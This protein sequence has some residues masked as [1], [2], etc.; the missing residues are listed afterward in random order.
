MRR[1]IGAHVLER[2]AARRRRASR[3]RARA[4]VQRP[5]VRRDQPSRAAPATP[6]AAGRTTRSAPG[7][8]SSSVPRRRLPTSMPTALRVEK[9]AEPSLHRAPLALGQALA[10]Q[11]EDRRPRIARPRRRRP[12]CACTVAS[13][14]TVRPSK[15]RSRISRFSSAPCAR[16]RCSTASKVPRPDVGV[17]REIGGGELGLRAVAQERATSRGWRRS[18]R[19]SR[20]AQNSRPTCCRAAG[21]SAVPTRRAAA[22]C[23]EQFVIKRAQ[24]DGRE[25]AAASSTSRRGRR[26]STRW[27]RA[28]RRRRRPRARRAPARSNARGAGAGP[29]VLAPRTRASRQVRDHCSP[30]QT[31]G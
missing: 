17:L 3:A 1:A 26:P 31:P 9:P 30:P 7:F 4:P 11:I 20:S 6:K 12:R 5:L 13:T 25:G 22:P 23:G 28:R 29:R 16:A 15:R 14:V 24:A 27:R 2:P 21:G 8:A 19:P 10:R 18:A